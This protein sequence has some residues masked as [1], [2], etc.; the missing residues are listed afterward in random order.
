MALAPAHAA[1]SRLAG[2]PQAPPDPILGVTEAFK[3]DADTARKL[4]LGVG[5]CPARPRDATRGR[6]RG[7]LHSSRR[8]AMLNNP[9]SLP[10]F[11]FAMRARR[12]KKPQSAA[13]EKRLLQRRAPWLRCADGACSAR[14]P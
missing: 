12:P 13:G 6:D 8:W 10:L 3:R 1:A 2:V 4:N 11:D 9:H 14:K 7:H 5:A